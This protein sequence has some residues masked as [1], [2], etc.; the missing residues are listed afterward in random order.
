MEIAL[1]GLKRN[2]LYIGGVIFL[3]YMHAFAQNNPHGK[4][5]WD[6]DACHS[7]TGWSS[8]TKD[9]QFKH[10]STGFELVG[11]HKMTP[12]RSCHQ[13]LKFANVG[14]ACSDCHEDIHQARLSSNC[15]TCHLPFSWNNRINILEKHS[16]KGFPL[17]G[18]HLNVDCGGCH[19]SSDEKQ[20][21]SMGTEC[22][23]CHKT[24]FES[25]RNPNHVE[26]NFSKNC[27]ICHSMGFVSWKAPEFSHTSTFMLRGAHQKI[28]CNAC[29]SNGFKIGKD[30]INC[31]QG[32]YNNSRNPDHKLANFPLDCQKCHSENA[33]Q[34]ADFDHSITNFPLTGTHKTLACESCH[35]NG[36]YSNLPVECYSCHQTDYEKTTDPNHAAAKFS[37]Q[38]DECHRTTSW[39]EV[40]WDH[41]SQYFPIYSGAHKGAWNTC[42]DCHVNP[43]DYTVFE[44]INCHEHS[45]SRMDDKH[46]EVRNYVYQSDA[47]YNCHPNGKGD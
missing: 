19:Q 38:C 28:D 16:E 15:E 11:R 21:T 29:H 31:H 2:I 8:L 27:V 33:W 34:P 26:A 18:V 43:N 22:V 12:C 44:C 4:I 30:C 37:L 13:S 17:T 20:Y 45:Q 14:T 7:E 24:V 41:D 36:N 32:D 23:L 25:T 35:K 6:C 39:N 10:G 40:T 9:M 1:F 5:S 47:C 3:L 42:N 46:G